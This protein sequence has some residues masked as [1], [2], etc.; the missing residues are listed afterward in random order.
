MYEG[1]KSIP[2]DYQNV[3]LD[4]MEML[5][6]LGIPYNY[7]ERDAYKMGKTAMEQMINRIA[8]PDKAYRHIMLESPFVRQTL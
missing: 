3:S 5:N 2:K 6:I 4:K 8:F 7:I 1:G